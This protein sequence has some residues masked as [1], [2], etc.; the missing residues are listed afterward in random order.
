MRR[1][2]GWRPPIDPEL[3][4]DVTSR[5]GSW[6]R[7]PSRPPDRSILRGTWQALVTQ[8]DNSS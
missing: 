5:L 1:G 7:P 2:V 4:G 6:Q 8:P 3:G